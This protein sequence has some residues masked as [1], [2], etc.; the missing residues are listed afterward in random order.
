VRARA[1]RRANATSAS[2]SI[3]A[4]RGPLCPYPSGSPATNGFGRK[5]R[6]G[7]ELHLT[8]SFRPMGHWAS[9]SAHGRGTSS[10]HRH[11]HR[12]LIAT[13]THTHLEGLGRPP[14]T[15]TA[16]STTAQTTSTSARASGRRWTRD[17]VLP[18]AQDRL[19]QLTSMQTRWGRGAIR[20]EEIAKAAQPKE[21][22]RSSWIAV[23]RSDPHKRKRWRREARKAARKYAFKGFTRVHP[24]GAGLRRTDTRAG[25]LEGVIRRNKLRRS[26][27][28]PL[29]IGRECRCGGGLRL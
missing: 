18:A 27:T 29:G 17:R 2:W 28:R 9:A 4:S 11:E 20:K 16:R 22:Q 26:S 19:R 8:V 21:E 1:T 7:V 15:A 13:T 25:D 10:E 14:L 3:V 6:D 23:A 5:P 12:Q 24:D